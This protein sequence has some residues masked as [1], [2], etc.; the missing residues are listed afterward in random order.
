MTLSTW[1]MQTAASL[2]HTLTLRVFRTSPASWR[3]FLSFLAVLND[4]VVGSAFLRVSSSS[5]LNRGGRGE[6][7][8]SNSSVTLF[9][10]ISPTTKAEAMASVQLTLTIRDEAVKENKP[11][12]KRVISEAKGASGYMLSTKR[13]QTILN[14]SFVLLH[15][16]DPRLTANNCYG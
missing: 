10:N 16:E 2:A 3:Y 7:V 1:V 14:Y 4:R 15:T 9:L 13:A 12:V 5:S 8:F 11:L 6:S